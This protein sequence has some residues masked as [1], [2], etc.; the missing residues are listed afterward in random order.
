MALRWK[1]AG[2]LCDVRDT[3]AAGDASASTRSGVCVTFKLLLLCAKLEP[4]SLQ[5][6]YVRGG[7][8]TRSLWALAARR[9]VVV[10][11]QALGQ[12]DW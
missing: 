3:A 5:K 7:W 11:C 12:V 2:S 10:E 6:H 1:L 9:T 8:G 4:R